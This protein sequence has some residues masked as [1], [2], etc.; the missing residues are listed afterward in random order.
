MKRLTRMFEGLLRKPAPIPSPH[1]LSTTRL[2]GGVIVR[3]KAD[4]PGAVYKKGDV[5]GASYEVLGV[6]GLGGFSV[7]YLVYSRES[8]AV[9]ALKTLRDDYLEELSRSP[10]AG[11]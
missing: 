4:H 5:I 8:R 6:L 9:S 11:P 1:G 2:P 3:I 10:W 7:V